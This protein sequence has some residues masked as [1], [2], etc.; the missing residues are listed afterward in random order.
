MIC[1]FTQSH[2]LD[3]LRHGIRTEGIIIDVLDL[4]YGNTSNFNLR[5]D[6]FSDISSDEISQMSRE[7]D[8]AEK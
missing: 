2:F 6:L 3:S 1:F 5:C 4:A 7:V 8:K